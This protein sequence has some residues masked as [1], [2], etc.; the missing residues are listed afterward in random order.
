MNLYSALVTIVAILAVVRLL[1][2]WQ[3]GRNRPPADAESTAR[4]AELE[5]RVR[6]L[7]RIITD[8][9]EALQR[10]FDDLA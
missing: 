10:K 8:D 7:E 5:E 3:A 4:V 2:D 9:R 6:T 1:R